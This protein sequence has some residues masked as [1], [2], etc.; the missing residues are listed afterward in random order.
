MGC[1]NSM[2]VVG[3]GDTSTACECSNRGYQIQLR[4]VGINGS[5]S[6]CIVISQCSL[7]ASTCSHFGVL[8]YT[9]YIRILNV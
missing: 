2:I 7:I 8:Q 5:R 1:T 9:V 4:C 6:S 3:G